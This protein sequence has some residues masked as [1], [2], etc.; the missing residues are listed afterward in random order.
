M[1]QRHVNVKASRGRQLPAAQKSK[2]SRI[3][4]SSK[5]S[6]T[7]VQLARRFEGSRRAAYRQS[8]MRRYLSLSPQAMSNYCELPFLFRSKGKGNKLPKG[9]FDFRERHNLEKSSK[10]LDSRITAGIPHLAR[11]T[12]LFHTSFTIRQYLSPSPTL[13]WATCALPTNFS[14]WISRPFL[15]ASTA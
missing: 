3:L 7:G 6:Q 14:S 12:E 8:V 13:A 15:L 5:S 11:L 9:N 4:E 10:F 2:R 1:P